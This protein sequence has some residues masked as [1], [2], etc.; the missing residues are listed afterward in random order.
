MTLLLMYVAAALL[1]T[2][3]VWAEDPVLMAGS[4]IFVMGMD[5]YLDV[6]WGIPI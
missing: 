5:W 4:I 6:V 2:V 3:D 1:P